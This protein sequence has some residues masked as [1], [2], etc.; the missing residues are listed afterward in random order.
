MGC[1]PGQWLR[2]IEISLVLE[3]FGI[4][5]GIPGGLGDNPPRPEDGTQRL[6]DRG[7]L[8]ESFGNDVPCSRQGRLDI[9]HLVIDIFP[10]LSL[11]IPHIDSIHKLSQRLQ[12]GLLCHNCPGTPLRTV[13]QI[14]V[15]EFGSID[16]ILHGNP[17]FG[18]KTSL[19]LYRGK[20]GGL[21]LLHLGEYIC[22][23]SDSGHL[24][25]VQPAGL[26]LAVTAYERY[27]A[28]LLEEG[29]AILYLPVLDSK[30][31]GDMGNVNMIHN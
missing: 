3:S 5:L 6:P 14:E 7:R 27:G 10:R 26:F 12:A 20:Y 13:R 11:K 30:C 1:Y 8:A 15:L 16:T 25:V 31:P 17:E 18:R 19:R 28:A 9:G 22:P 23:M 2:I 29:G 4:V 21:P 24:F